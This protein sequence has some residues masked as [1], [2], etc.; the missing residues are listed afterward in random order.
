MPD[1]SNF[2]PNFFDRQD[3]SDDALFYAEPRF[4]EHIDAATI[5]ALTNVYRQML[6][7]GSRVLDMMS[8]WVSHLPPELEFGR[9]A[10][11]GMNH[12]ELARNPR[13]DDYVVHDLNREPELPYPDA[14]FDHVVI[15][16]SIQYLAR[17]VDVFRS[18]LRTLKP[19]GCFVIAMSHRCFPTKA[20]RGFCQLAAKDRIEL[21]RSY[22]RHAGGYDEAVFLDAS[23][24]GA[25]P[26]WVISA[27]R[28][29][30]S[31]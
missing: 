16:V 13:L 20:V 11:L 5:A 19:G 31:G 17:P 15:A 18:V 9:V 22:F 26:L 10:G 28:S 24:D 1:R 8:S 12:Q 27:L 30:T 3:E 21:V 23:P 29:P 6:S 14:T 2:P 7:P 25:D 4:V